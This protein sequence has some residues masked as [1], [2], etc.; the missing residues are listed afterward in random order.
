M[1]IY[2]NKWG[3]SLRLKQQTMKKI[4]L[5]LLAAICSM[6]LFAQNTFQVPSGTT[7]KLTGGAYIVL[8]DI[9]LVNNSTLVQ[10][11]GNGNIKFIGNTD[12]TFSG[13]GTT[14]I[15]HLLL[16]KGAASKINLQ[17]NIAV[18][19]GIDFSGGLLNLGTSIINL[20]TTALLSNESETSNAY[21]LSTGYIQSTATLNAPSSANPGSLGAIITSASNLGSTVIRRSFLAANN[22]YG[23]GSSILRKYIITPTNNTSLN[24]TFRF[25]YLDAELNG[26]AEGSLVSWKSPD[27]TH[28]TAQGFTT[29]NT[30]TNY[31]ELTGITDFSSW[32]LSTALNTLPVAFGNIKAFEQGSDIIVQWEVAAE[33]NAAKYNIQRS[34]DGNSFSNIGYVTAANLS[35]YRFADHQPLTGNNYYRIWIVDRDNSDKLS[36][37]V[38][39]NTSK[40]KPGIAIFPNPATGQQIILQFASMEKGTYHLDLFNN[41]GQKIYTGTINHAGGSSAETLQLPAN[42][43]SGVYQLKIK[44][45]TSVF[46]QSLILQ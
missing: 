8:R 45:K 6:Q 35:S 7:L 14:T 16:A 11:S 19:S 22:S 26:L 9:N 39:I 17:T 4:I 24:A 38:T 18:V 10:A 33:L 42:I 15:D 12:V 13:S 27:N 25:Q 37:V 31:V 43:T 34:S 32:T 21:S 1:K 23:N 5:I 30:T 20:G 44:S 29:R 40:A 2:K 3:I 41:S 28:W 36:R 46:N